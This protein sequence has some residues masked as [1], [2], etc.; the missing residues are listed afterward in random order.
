[1]ATDICVMVAIT[2]HVSPK[3]KITSISSLF[4][5]VII[6]ILFY[7]YDRASAN[8]TP[9]TEAKWRRP[10]HYLYDLNKLQPA[11]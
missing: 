6:V 3:I 7:F 9:A 1:M 11:N 2:E 4:K 5:Q 10:I 8:Q